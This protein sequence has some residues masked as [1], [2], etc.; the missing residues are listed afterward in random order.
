MKSHDIMTLPTLH[1]CQPPALASSLF[2]LFQST[3]TMPKTQ[4]TLSFGSSKRPAL[5]EIDGN[6]PKRPKPSP[7]V[8]AQP[9]LS[10]TNLEAHLTGLVLQLYRQEPHHEI[11]GSPCAGLVRL[12]CHPMGR[13]NGQCWMNKMK[14]VASGIMAEMGDRWTIE[15][16]WMSTKGQLQI[17][18]ATGSHSNE[19]YASIT[20]TRLLAF[21]AS[22]TPE[23]WGYLTSAHP[24]NCPF[25]HRCGRGHIR[26]DGTSLGCLNGIR[27]GEVSVLAKKTRIT[28]HAVME[29]LHYAQG[30]AL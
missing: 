9:A 29:L 1:S 24:I 27:H 6:A 13:K 25:S 19:V 11:F 21:F 15:S 17:T 8:P 2:T 23:N 5:E 4:S 10:T 12:P 3:L 22:P 20:I 30:T 14:Q 18:N 28:N 26:Y 16:C 7:Q